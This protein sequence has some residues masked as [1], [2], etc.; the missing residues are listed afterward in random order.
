MNK[1]N[2][3]QQVSFDLDKATDITCDNCGHTRF[4]TVYLL[5][6]LSALVSPTG[7]E[8]IV[9][10]AAFA[11]ASCDHINEEFLSN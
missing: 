6:R 4:K 2:T 7:D 1:P 10:M 9:P 5:K 3:N 11:C 8:T